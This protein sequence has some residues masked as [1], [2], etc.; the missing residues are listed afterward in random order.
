MNLYDETIE[1]LENHDKTIADIE[2]IGTLKDK[3]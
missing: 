1:T 3:N 2:Y